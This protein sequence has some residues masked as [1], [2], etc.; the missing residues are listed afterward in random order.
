M[1]ALSWLLRSMNEKLMMN[2]YLQWDL[3]NLIMVCI[4]MSQLFIA[5]L[6]ISLI[7]STIYFSFSL[8]LPIISLICMNICLWRCRLLHIE[9]LLQKMQL[10][11]FES[12][13]LRLCIDLNSCSFL[14]DIPYRKMYIYF[15][16]WLWAESFRFIARIWIKL[17]F[18]IKTVFTA[19]RLSYVQEQIARVYSKI[20]ITT[21]SL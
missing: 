14:F 8:S 17:K 15:T 9:L 19:G 12:N 1:A 6:I 11:L 2:L 7:S 21:S 13:L 5:L 10:V 3:W 4:L 16:L 18:F 20:W